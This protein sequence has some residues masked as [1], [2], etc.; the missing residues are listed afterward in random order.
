MFKLSVKNILF[1]IAYALLNAAL[2][3]G[4]IYII[5]NAISRKKDFLFNYT[6]I[7]FIAIVGYTY[8]LNIIFQKRLNQY[9]YTVLYESEKHI[10]KKMLQ[11]PLLTLEKYGSQ[12]FYAIIQDLRIFSSLSQIVTH[13]L[14]SVLM[15]I[16]CLV[17]MFT[18]SVY[19]ALIVLG[20]II[21]LAAI[22]F[23][24]MKTMSKELSVLRKYSEHYFGYV[25]DVIRGFKNFK[26][27][28]NKRNNLMRNYLNPN[29]NNAGKLDY[30]INF[31]FLS[32]N[33]ISQYGLYFVIGIILFLLPFFS[34][35]STEETGSYV[36]V[37]LL[38][39][40][41]VNN[42]I[43]MQNVYSQYAA[44][45]IRI[46]EFL[47][48]FQ[49]EREEM[50]AANE[51]AD[52]RFDSIE[53]RNLCFNYKNNESDDIFGI[54]PV[55]LKINLG[56][57]IFIIG[58]NGSGK[59]TFLNVLTG[60]Y[61]PSDGE[62]VLSNQGNNIR[63]GSIQDYIAAIFTDN[64]LF[65]HNYDDYSLKGNEQYKELLKFMEMD[66]AIIDDQEESARRNFSKGQGK[67]M[68]MIFALLENKPILVL[69]E[70]AADQDPYFRKYF[71]KILL[72]QLKKEG[73]TVIAV[74]HDDAYFKYAD[75]IVKFDY[76]KIVQDF[77][78][79]DE[80]ILADRL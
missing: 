62:V 67:R 45:D 22:F 35:L 56:E 60:L 20:L 38:I 31:V 21:T 25:N 78:V 7:V 26:I 29:R 6:G 15:I 71:Y 41:P 55:D 36:V 48:D 13:T 32:I 74:T 77:K 44:A 68:S 66:T 70:W 49:N 2:T 11:T 72:P 34:L 69:D 79:N 27:D 10:F 73:K 9:T 57:L 50:V 65:S 47:A 42:L 33:L 61:P 59:S 64:H 14:N 16:L 23:I 54:G 24:V 58:G 4:I 52:K 1:L 37:V 43:N 39:S 17:Y 12:R 30:K 80:V 3:F 8:L 75:R 18:I 40:G 51:V 53:I 46:K 28:K 19:S 76:G 5:N 63:G